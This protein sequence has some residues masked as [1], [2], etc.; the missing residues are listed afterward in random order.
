MTATSPF[1]LV[2]FSMN[3]GSHQTLTFAVYDS[4]SNPVS[5]SGATVTWYL[6]HYG[7]PSA[8]VTKVGTSGS[9]TNQ[10][11]VDVLGGDTS[12]F[13]GKFVQQYKIVDASGSLFRP[14][15]GIITIFPALE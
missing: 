3:A 6:S 13:S 2:E 1:D 10:F 8:L 9:S 14:S 15:S 4:S 7:N 12:T 11:I 5:L